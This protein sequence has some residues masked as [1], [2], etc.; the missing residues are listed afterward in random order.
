MTALLK[1]FDLASGLVRLIAQ[2]PLHSEMVTQI[3][4]KRS[5]FKCCDLHVAL[6]WFLFSIGIGLT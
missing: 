5:G 1:R 2:L 3:V 4:L 6:K